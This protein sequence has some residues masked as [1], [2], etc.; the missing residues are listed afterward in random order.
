[1]GQLRLNWCFG[2]WVRYGFWSWDSPKMK[3]GSLWKAWCSDSNPKPT[4]TPNHQGGCANIFTFSLKWKS[5]V[6]SWSPL[7]RNFGR[8]TIN[9]VSA[10]ETNS[11]P[12]KIDVWKLIHFGD[13]LPIFRGVNCSFQGG[14]HLS[15]HGTHLSMWYLGVAVATL[16]HLQIPGPFPMTWGKRAEKLGKRVQKM[17]GEKKNP[18]P[19]KV[20]EK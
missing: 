20:G 17:D 9:R 11:S 19:G 10:P 12:L 15:C 6:S 18:P 3:P 13:D 5:I 16:L 14:A 4:G 1:M 7:E 8:T 2:A